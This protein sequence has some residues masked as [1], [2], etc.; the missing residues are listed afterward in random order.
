M[1]GRGTASDPA[2]GGRGKEQ[3][4]RIAAR[5]PRPCGALRFHQPMPIHCAPLLRHCHRPSTLVSSG[6]ERRGPSGLAQ[7]GVPRGQKR[8]FLLPERPGRVFI[9]V[10][11]VGACNICCSALILCSLLLFAATGVIFCQL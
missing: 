10:C 5:T 8:R 4:A 1:G 3:T 6:T 9:D 2:W 7:G 11:S